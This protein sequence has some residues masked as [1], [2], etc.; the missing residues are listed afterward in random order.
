VATN[1]P[2]LRS[3]RTRADSCN[4]GSKNPVATAPGFDLANAD[5]WRRATIYE[6]RTTNHERAVRRQLFDD[7]IL[8]TLGVMGIFLITRGFL[9]TTRFAGRK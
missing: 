5:R 1:I 6:Q 4:A 8:A 7:S 3:S 9:E 2:L